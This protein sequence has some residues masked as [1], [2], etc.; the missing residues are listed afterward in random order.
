MIERGREEG[1]EESEYK[2]KVKI[3]KKV[4]LLQT[5]SFFVPL[6]LCSLEALSLD[7]VF[8]AFYLSFSVCVLDLFASTFASTVVV[9]V[10]VLYLSNVNLID[11]TIVKEWKWKK[12]EKE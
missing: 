7:F 5:K 10:V 11:N 2:E 6:F 12:G 8:F 3:Q 1:E 9:V 4:H